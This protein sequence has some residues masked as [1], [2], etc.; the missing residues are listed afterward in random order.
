[1][2]SHQETQRKYNSTVQNKL[3]N[4][5]KILKENENWKNQETN[6]K[7]LEILSKTAIK[8]LGERDCKLCL[9]SNRK[10]CHGLMMI[11]EKCSNGGEKKNG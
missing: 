3:I 9:G 1:M 4:R 5:F 2:E 6:A 10:E 11:A 8:V 7:L